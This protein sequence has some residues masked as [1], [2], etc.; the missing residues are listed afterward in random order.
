[1]ANKRDVGAFLFVEGSPF[2]RDYYMMLDMAPIDI[3]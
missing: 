2:S 1:M 3:I